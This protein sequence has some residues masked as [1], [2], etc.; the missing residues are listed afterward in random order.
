MANSRFYTN[1]LRYQELLRLFR[2]AGFEPEVT[3]KMEWETLPTPRQKMA[4]EF[5]ALPE[6]DLKVSDFDVLL[7]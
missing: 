4:K 6:D 1:R 7:R 3:R 2:E 5:A